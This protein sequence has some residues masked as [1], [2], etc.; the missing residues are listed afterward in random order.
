M[1]KIENIA[2]GKEIAKVFVGLYCNVR[3]W[4]FKDFTETLVKEKPAAQYNFTALCFEWFRKLSEVDWNL[5]DD[6][7]KRSGMLAD[8]IVLNVNIDDYRYKDFR[9]KGIRDSFDVD[10]SSGSGIEKTVVDYIK[11][12]KGDYRDFMDRAASEHKTLQQNFSRL[13]VEWFNV[14][15]YANTG[16]KAAHI[17]AVRK[18]LTFDTSLPYI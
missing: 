12:S 8:E 2:D 5:F 13:C 16:S 9:R 11:V 4:N 1:I 3:S 17:K 14:Y 18:I 7:N 10:Y 6:R 15:T